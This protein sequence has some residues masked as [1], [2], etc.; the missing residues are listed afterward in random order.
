[1]DLRSHDLAKLW[2]NDSELQMLE[3]VIAME[4]IFAT[5]APPSNRSAYT[6]TQFLGEIFRRLGFDGVL[7]KSTVG[8]GDNLVAFNPAN[9]AWISG[10]SRAID[11]KRVSYEWVDVNLFDKSKDYDVDFDQNRKQVSS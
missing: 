5:A 2:H 4:R 7:F 3:L 1:M 9:A 8:G 10:S 6:L 11:V